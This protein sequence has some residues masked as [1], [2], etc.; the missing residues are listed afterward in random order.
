[1]N[2]KKIFGITTTLLLFT[3]LSF[4]QRQ[5]SPQAKVFS[6]TKSMV[7][8]VFGK[9][10]HGSGFLVDN[11]GLVVTNDHV[12]GDDPQYLSVQ[13]NDTLKVSAQIIERDS[14]KDI[15]V[16]A[17]NPQ[18]VSTLGLEALN[19]SATSDT[20]VFVGESVIAIGSPLNQMKILTT[21]IV[22]KVEPNTIIH[23][24]NI[25]P[26]NSGGPLINMN[27]DVIGINTFGDMTSRGPGIYGSILISEASQILND[28]RNSVSSMDLTEISSSMLPVMP[29]EV[30]PFNALEA[31][32]AQTF[33][34]TD[35]QIKAGKFELM[36]QTPPQVYSISKQKEKKLASKRNTSNPDGSPNKYELYSDLKEWMSSTGSYQ[37]VVRLFVDPATGQTTGSAVL[38]VLGAA[39]SGYTGTSYYGSYTYE[40]KADVKDV[41]VYRDGIEVQPI[42]SSYQYRTLDFNVVGYSGRAQ[43]EDM[44]QSAMLTFPIEVFLPK[45][46][47][48]FPTIQ[49]AITNFMDGTSSSWDIPKNTIYKINMDFSPLTGDQ[50]GKQFYKPPP[51]GCS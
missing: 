32:T 33:F 31:S 20:M 43:G 46:N 41:K 7:C 22:S 42:L 26:G 51:Q 35:Y 27:A 13:F 17:V 29:K 25:N 21:G 38:N 6:A 24:A 15:A 36:F 8:T 49:I 4:S 2:M 9:A 11:A 18:V 19:L 47:S 44:A 45:E 23:D 10:G 40:Y 30:F 37:P 3:S 16:I 12:L 14:R 34:A 28:A 39:A 50:L 1:L 5:V 48:A